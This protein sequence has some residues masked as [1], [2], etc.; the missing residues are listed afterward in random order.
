MQVSL[1]FFPGSLWMASKLVRLKSNLEILCDT[2]SFTLASH[3][4]AWP[5]FLSCVTWA[6]PIQHH[7]CFVWTWCRRKSAQSGTGAF[8]ENHLVE[9]VTSFNKSLG[10]YGY[11]VRKILTLEESWTWVREDGIS[12]MRKGLS[13]NEVIEGKARSQSAKGFQ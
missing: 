9:W 6:S 5:I 11:H 1:L 4:R 12:I 2:I 10:E 13:S 3:P 8:C 7:K